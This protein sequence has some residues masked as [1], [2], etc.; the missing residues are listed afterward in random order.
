[1]KNLTNL[2]CF[3]I[4]SG[5]ILTTSC[6]KTT[7]EDGTK[8]ND[9]DH[10]ENIIGSI[11]AKIDGANFSAKT[12]FV[13]GKLD[14]SNGLYTISMAAGDLSKGDTA[15]IAIALVGQDFNTLKEG[16]TFL[17]TNLPPN[18]IAAAKYVLDKD[19]R[20]TEAPADKTITVTITE[21]NRSR[22]IVSGTFTFEAVDEETSQIYNITDGVF[23]NIEYK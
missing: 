10:T 17:G 18:K 21:L 4:L 15:G 5:V 13:T 22:K 7:D 2:F 11:T 19:G 16:D 23:T 1:M 9:T 8:T 6:K 20:E 14:E 3:F 12:P